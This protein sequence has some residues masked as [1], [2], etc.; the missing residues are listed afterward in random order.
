[1]RTVLAIIAV[2]TCLVVAILLPEINLIFELIGATTGSFVCFIGPGL[3]LCRLVPGRTFS[4]PKLNGVL[5]VV[6][7]CIFLSLGTYSSVLDVVSQLSNKAPA[8][9]PTCPVL[10]KGK[11]G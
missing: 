9:S 11:S 2:A 10:A 5:L 8:S 6:V 7:G 4:G 1:V 3:M